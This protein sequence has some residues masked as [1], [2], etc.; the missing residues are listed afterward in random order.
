MLGLTQEKLGGAIGLTFQQVQKY[1]RGANRLGA[2][3][4]QELAE[5]LDVPVAFFFDDTDPVHAPAMLRGLSQNEAAEADPLQ[6][7]ETGEL[8]TSYYAIAEPIIRR[9]FFQLAKA[10]AVETDKPS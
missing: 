10:L 9:R 2:S 7:E 5:V 1:E 8:V 4:L 6:R 3:R